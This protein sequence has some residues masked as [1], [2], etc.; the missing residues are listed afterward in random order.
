MGCSNRHIDEITLERVF[1]DAWLALMEDKE[2]CK[3]KWNKLINEKNPLIAYRAKTLLEYSEKDINEF[4]TEQM[5]GTLESI[6]V[7]ETGRIV[8]R[9]LDGTE[10][11]IG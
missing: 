10:V 1:V 3:V 11:E 8:L 2:R 9:L 5:H 6:I 4:D 7:F